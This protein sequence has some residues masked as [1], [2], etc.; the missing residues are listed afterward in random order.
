MKTRVFFITDVH[1]STICFKKFLNAHSV[2]KADVLILGGD[3]TGKALVPIIERGDGSYTLEFGG[4][5]MIVEKG[6]LEGVK[7]MIENSGQY[8]HI[9]REEDFRRLSENP[10]ELETLFDN[11]MAERLKFW[12]E[13]AENKLKGKNVECYISPGNDDKRMV[14]TLLNGHVVR[15]PE[16]EIVEIKGRYEMI[17][18]GLSNMTP[19]KSPREVSEEELERII[20]DLASKLRE[21]KSSIFNFHVPPVNTEIDKAPAV[22]AN[23]EYQRDVMGVKIIHAGSIAVRRAIERYQ[24][25]LGLHG[26]IHESRGCVKIGSTYCINPGSEYESGILRGAIVDLDNGKVRDYLLTAG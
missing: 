8:Y 26:H 17:T 21:H 14:D 22:N 15:N 18:V 5:R 2:Y 3:I 10:Y 11:L 24:P 4:K 9:A 7:N 16:Q 6:Q 12:I 25:A 19:W 20:E 23:L 13:L 1:G